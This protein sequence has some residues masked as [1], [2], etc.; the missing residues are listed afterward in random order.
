MSTCSR[1]Q[2][3][4]DRRSFRVLQHDKER[5]RDHLV[6]TPVRAL[7]SQGCSDATS[8]AAAHVLPQVGLGTAERGQSFLKLLVLLLGPRPPVE[9]FSLGRRRRGL[10]R[11]SS[12]DV[13]GGGTGRRG[14]EVAV[15]RAG[16]RARLLP[17]PAH[18]RRRAGGM[19]V[20]S[21]G[22]EEGSILAG[23]TSLWGGRKGGGKAMR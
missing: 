18:I 7:I 2:A 16:R 6:L 8:V 14:Q 17:D 23:R 12:S 22:R 10:L 20:R 3:N 4:T 11:R 13:G 1:F 5:G 9:H 19:V 15:Q 21:T